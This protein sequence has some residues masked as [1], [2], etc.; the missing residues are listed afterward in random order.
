M[1][2]DHVAAHEF[3]APCNALADDEPVVDDELEVE[4]RDPDAR[5]ALA[6]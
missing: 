2:E 1:D 5:I 4:V 6:L 3:L